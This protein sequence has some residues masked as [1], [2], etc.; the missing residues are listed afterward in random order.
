[1]RVHLALV[2]A[3]TTV[4]GAKFLPVETESRANSD[5][6]NKIHWPPPLREDLVHGSLYPWLL[7]SDIVI[8][9]LTRRNTPN[10]P[11][12]WTIRYIY[13]QVHLAHFSLLPISHYGSIPRFTEWHDRN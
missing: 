8:G 5:E 1:M 12:S 6:P 10:T 7:K 2:P 13:K 4:T 9:P 11:H 3:C